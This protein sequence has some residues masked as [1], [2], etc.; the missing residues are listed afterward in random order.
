M[1]LQ[2]IHQIIEK[3]SYPPDDPLLDDP[4]DDP[5]AYLFAIINFI[6]YF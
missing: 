4:P 1:I 6:F 5:P 3:T 2:M